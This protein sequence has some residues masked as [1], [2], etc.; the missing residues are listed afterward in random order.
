MEYLNKLWE[1]ITSKN[2]MA[3]IALFGVGFGIYQTYFYEK[4]KVLTISQGAFTK[5]FDVYQPVGGLE[6]SYA[7]EN[8][9]NSK[10][11]L[12]AVNFTILNSGE[13][14]IKIGDFDDKA[15]LGI[16]VQGGDIVDQPKYLASNDYIQKTLE[17]KITKEK[18]TLSPIILESK[19]NINFSML[20]LGSV[21]IQ[22]KLIALG[23]VAGI[24][25]ITK[26]SAMAATGKKSI[27]RNAT[28]ADS[29]LVQVVRYF[30]Y[31][32]LGTLALGLCMLAVITPFAAIEDALAVRKRKKTLL[33]FKHNEDIS[34]E[35]RYL[36]ELYQESGMHDLKGVWRAIEKRKIYHTYYEK[37]SAVDDSSIKKEILDKIINKNKGRVEFSLEK[38]GMLTD[39]D[40]VPNYS[41]ELEKAL[42]ELMKFLDVEKFEESDNEETMFAA[43]IEIGKLT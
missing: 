20:V 43:G 35:A 12:W 42:S 15:P 13:T 24:G 31:F 18:I 34:K 19:D 33:K 37:L 14:G 1:K 39:D 11:V 5:V 23:V 29:L 36:I 30:T 22:P 8:L 28:E 2:F 10:K 40:G 9:R 4:S 16:A 38:N 21:D 17:L 6:I 25:Q 26:V 32:F 41:P 3:V 27:W 7:G